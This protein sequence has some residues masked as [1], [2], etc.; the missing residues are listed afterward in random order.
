MKNYY[1]FPLLWAFQLAC[2]L[3]SF[4]TFATQCGHATR[5]LKLSTK[6]GDRFLHRGKSY[7]WNLENTS[8]SFHREYVI[9]EKDT[10]QRKQWWQK[11]CHKFAYLTMKNNSFA[12]FEHASLIFWTF[13]RCSC[14]FH[15]MWTTWALDDKFLASYFHA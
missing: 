14:S 2:Y 10:L 15:K 9:F 6:Y 11:E 8:F 3:R 1:H 5:N 7:K 13:Q 12:H 4:V